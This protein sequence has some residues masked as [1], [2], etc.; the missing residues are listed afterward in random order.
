MSYKPKPLNTTQ[1]AVLRSALG[2]PT[3][4]IEAIGDRT[5]LKA[6][7]DRGFAVEIDWTGRAIVETDKGDYVFTDVAEDHVSLGRPHAPFSFFITFVGRERARF[8]A[9]KL[10]L[11]D[12][13]PVDPSLMQDLQAATAEET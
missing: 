12:G 8:A 13:V 2:N 5:T 10:Q 4:R 1:L 7:R 3:G 9:D 11:R 6:L